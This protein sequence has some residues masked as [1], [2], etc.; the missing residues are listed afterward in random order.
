ML[1]RDGGKCAACGLEAEKIKLASRGSNCPHGFEFEDPN[2]AGDYLRAERVAYAVGIKIKNG[3]HRFAGNEPLQRIIDQT[4]WAEQEIRSQWME[5]GLDCADELPFEKRESSWWEADHI[6]PVAEGGGGC[7]PEGYRT[8]CLRC[9]RAET[10]K[11]AGRLAEAR[12][13]KQNP[14]A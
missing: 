7:G 10:K 13:S 4:I 9:H 12:R 3:S 1:K 2:Y 11:L 5:W 8:L 6:I 14:A